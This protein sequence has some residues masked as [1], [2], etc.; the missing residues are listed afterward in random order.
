MSGESIRLYNTSGVH[1]EHLKG[2]KNGTKNTDNNNNTQSEHNRKKQNT[3]KQDLPLPKG[4]TPYALAKSAEY[5]IRDL[6]LAEYYYQ[7]AIFEGERIESAVKDLASL[8]HQ[9]GKTKEACEI[10][11]KYRFLFKHDYE[12]YL[13]LYNTLKKQIDSTGNCLNKSLKI[14]NLSIDDT[15]E[16]IKSFF[17]NSIRIQDIYIGKEEV[18]GKEAFYCKIRFNSHSSA[19]KTLEGFH[20]WDKYDVQ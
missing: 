7:K 12:K 15:E 13:N 6:D 20:C 8:L 10:L 11:E 1:K 3:Q 16:K 9:R 14:S 5:K 19:R 18:D 17:T 2:F 4:Q